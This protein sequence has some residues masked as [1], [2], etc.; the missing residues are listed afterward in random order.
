MRLISWTLQSRSEQY[1]SQ[2][3]RDSQ[4]NSPQGR[5]QLPSVF[6][7]GKLRLPSVFITGESFWTPWSRFTDFQ[8]NTTIFK[9][10][11]ILKI[12]FRLL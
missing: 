4:V 7:T 9:G 12:Y 11:V 1:S 3:S 2:E 5:L 10:N 8:E 6:T